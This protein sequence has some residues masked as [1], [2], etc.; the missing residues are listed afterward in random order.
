[1][2]DSLSLDGIYGLLAASRRRYI[3]YYVS[4]NERTSVEELS[5]QVTA[6]ENDEPVSAVGESDRRDVVV[7]LRHAH[8]PKLESH[9]VVE[10]DER[11]GKV[12]TVDGFETLWRSV[13]RAWEKED[14]TTA[15]VPPVSLP[16]GEPLREP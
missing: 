2:T 11:S 5:L 1:M 13:E 9:G 12:V 16:S 3:L 6:W 15:D 4:E 10:Y 14:V 7:S 8:L